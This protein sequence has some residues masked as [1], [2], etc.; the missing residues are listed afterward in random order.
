MINCKR[1]R[2]YNLSK[3]ER[4]RKIVWDKAKEIVTSG[5]ERKR[6]LDIASFTNKYDGENT[7]KKGVVTVKGLTSKKGN[8]F[9]A[10]MRYE[11]ITITNS[12]A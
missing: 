3:I 9:D 6:F 8:K 4:F 1:Y 11:K 10:N 5:Y 7:L 2:G 12:S